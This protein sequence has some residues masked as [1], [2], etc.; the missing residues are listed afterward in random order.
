[1]RAEVWSVNS[2]GTGA[3]PL[4]TE[5]SFAPEWSPDGTHILFVT[6]RDGNREVYSMTDTGSEQTNLSNDPATDDGGTFDMLRWSPD[7][8]KILF[9]SSR[10]AVSELW[11][12]SP[13]G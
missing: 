3:I 4:A 8:T 9:W 6:S 1:M 5:A 11:T 10:S 12:M 7:G 13:T 2:D